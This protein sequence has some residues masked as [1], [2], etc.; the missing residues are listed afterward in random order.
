MSTAKK[1]QS[2]KNNRRNR[3]PR[4]NRPA[5]VPGSSDS[6]LHASYVR[7]QQRVHRALVHRGTQQ[8]EQLTRHFALPNGKDL[9]R[10]P[11][12]DMPRTT[13]LIFNQR[14]DF[15]ESSAYSFSTPSGGNG[16][17]LCVFM[18]GLPSFAA[19][20]GPVRIQNANSTSITT[21]YFG[22]ASTN[23]STY[24]KLPWNA[25]NVGTTRGVVANWPISDNAVTQNNSPS[26]PLGCPKRPIMIHDARNFIFMNYGEKF[27]VTITPDADSNAAGNW[28]FQIYR[29]VADDADAFPEKFQNIST[30]GT[31]VPTPTQIA[32]DYAG[33]YSIDFNG[34][35]ATTGNIS[36]G[37][38]QVGIVCTDDIAGWHIKYPDS[39]LTSTS[40]GTVC[41]RTAQT[42]LISNMSSDLNA[43]GS[44]T[45]NRNLTAHPGQYVWG[46]QIENLK[47]TR[48]F[49]TERAKKGCYSYMDFSANAEPFRA[50]VNDVGCPILRSSDFSMLMHV[51]A[52]SNGAISTAPNTYAITLQT[53][54]E[55]QSQ[56]Q[57]FDGKV[58]TGN[59]LDLVEARRINNDTPYFYENPIHWNTIASHIR[60][61]WQNFQKVSPYVQGGLSAFFPEAAPALA[62][63]GNAI[64]QLPS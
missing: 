8:A 20:V 43:Q 18:Y 57:L 54:L 59:F 16:S 42:V 1:P 28:T 13:A 34:V 31:T 32:V 58:P 10:I 23:L 39:L 38:I 3:Q 24:W 25:G 44:I 47:Q 45:A 19:L 4:R 52:V 64:R 14:V 22:N 55:F 12:Q 61:A 29:Y 5:P 30:T 7:A 62:I 49:I 48:E 56:S 51:M 41:R 46:S 15:T 35:L 2:A 63:A 37:Q 36:G 21:C 26:F 9:V 50:Y 40:V 11:T 17:N 27:N 33:W 6:M 53:A 60:K